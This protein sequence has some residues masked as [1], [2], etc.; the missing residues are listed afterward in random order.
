MQ[1]EMYSE[2]K[3]VRKK[4]ICIQN[5]SMY[6]SVLGA[7]TCTWPVKVINRSRLAEMSSFKKYSKVDSKGLSVKETVSQILTINV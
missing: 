4:N 3:I 2:K 7:K 6:V 5:Y 1:E